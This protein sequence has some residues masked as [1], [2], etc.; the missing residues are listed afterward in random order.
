[1]DGVFQHG[2]PVF[3]FLYQTFINL[4]FVTGG[5]LGNLDLAANFR[6]GGG[7]G[8]GGGFGGGIDIGVGVGGGINFGGI[9]GVDDGEGGIRFDVGGG[10]R[11]G[12]SGSAMTPVPSPTGLSLP[13]GG[14]GNLFI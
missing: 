12:L 6:F 10:L 14:I 2:T 9:G 4:M 11:L 7:G 13:C 5:F 3:R 1:M 8:V